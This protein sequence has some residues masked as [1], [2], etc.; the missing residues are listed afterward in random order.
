MPAPFRTTITEPDLPEAH[1][2]Q[3][4]TKCNKTRLQF[5][6]TTNNNNSSSGNN[7]IGEREEKKLRCVH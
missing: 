4:K 5:E 2:E 1:A 7:K 6:S 3:Q